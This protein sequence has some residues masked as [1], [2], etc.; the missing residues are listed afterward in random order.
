MKFSALIVGLLIPAFLSAAPQ[1]KSEHLTKPWKQVFSDSIGKFAVDMSSF[2][3]ITPKDMFSF[4]MAVILHQPAIHNGAQVMATIVTMQGSCKQNKVK[5]T[6]DVII[7]TEGYE[8][9]KNVISAGDKMETPE[10]LSA[11]GKVLAAI[12]SGK[13]PAEE[14]PVQITQV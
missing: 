4:N 5:M 14:A 6:G 12:C 11:T 10:P 3:V 7:S 9:D 2:K 8:I 13:T 1:T